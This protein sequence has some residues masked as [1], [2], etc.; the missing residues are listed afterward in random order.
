M[1]P[2]DI[3]FSFRGFHQR[4]GPTADHADGFGVAFF[5]GSGCRMFV[6]LWPAVHSPDDRIAIVATE[7]LTDN[8][9]WV[10]FS[11]GE[12]IALQEGGSAVFLG[13][14]SARAHNARQPIAAPVLHSPAPQ[15]RYTVSAN[16]IGR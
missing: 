5:E 6:D 7:P 11:A 15:G 14:R 16:L 12:L 13:G 2:T 9:R 10:P 3:C 8:E 1:C 4:G